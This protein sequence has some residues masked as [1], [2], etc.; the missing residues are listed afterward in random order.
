MKRFSDCA[1]S[2]LS[3]FGFFPATELRLEFSSKRRRVILGSA[4]L[5]EGDAS[6]HSYIKPFHSLR[7]VTSHRLVPRRSSTAT[8]R[9]QARP[10]HTTQPP[11]FPKIYEPIMTTKAPYDAPYAA[12]DQQEVN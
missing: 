10:L 7:Q 2:R 6:S 1:C 3:R 4:T 11:H 8:S 12:Q 9:P 5:N